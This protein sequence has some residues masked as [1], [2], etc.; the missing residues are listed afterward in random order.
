MIMPDNAELGPLDVQLLKVDELGE[1][2]SGLTITD[3]MNTLKTQAFDMFEDYFLQLR[4]KSGQQITTK[5]AAEIAANITVGLYSPIYE[6]IDPMRL[7]ETERALRIALEYGER[8]GKYNLKPDALTKLVAGYPDHGFVID[9]M[10]AETLFEKVRFPS[11][12]EIEVANELESIVDDSLRK[13]EA[14]LFNLTK[15]ISTEPGEDTNEQGDAKSCKPDQATQ[16]PEDSP[17][18]EAAEQEAVANSNGD[19]KQVVTKK[20][21]QLHQLLKK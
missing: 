16:Q 5:S 13:G 18:N 8:V 10:E 21:G 12:L 11:E 9:R 2:S 14:I 6:Q 20:P 19:E 1:R 15:E 7:G 17:S 3:A 4:F